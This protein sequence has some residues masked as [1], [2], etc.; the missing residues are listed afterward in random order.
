[1]VIQ[2]YIIFLIPL[3]LSLI[4]TPAVIRLARRIGA[5]DQPNER[6]IHKLPIPR[7]GGLAIYAS[8][9]LS[10]VLYYYFDPAIHP[11]SSMHPRTGV[12]LAVSL[13][14]VLILGIWDDVKQLSPG[15]KFFFQCLAAAIVYFAGFRIASITH[16]FSSSL[17]DLGILNFP[18]T[19]LWIVGITNAFNLIDGLDGLAGGIAFIASLTVCTISFIDGDL[20]TA[21]MALMLAGS[22][23][24][25]LR[26]NF[27]GARIFLGDSGSLFLGFSLAI[28]SMVSSTKGSTAFSILVPVLALGLPIMDTLLSMARRFLHSVFPEDEEPKTFFKKL[29]TMFLPDR[30]HIHHQLI[31]RG[32]SHR[33]VVLL[34][35]VVS[36]LFGLG[37]FMVTLA[38]N[39]SVTPVLIAIGVASVIG[40]SQLKYK[41]MAMLRDGALLPLYEWPLM[42]SI[43]FHGFLDLAFTILAYAGACYLCRPGLSFDDQFLK[44]IM[45]VSGIQISVFY[46]TGLYKGMLR[47]FGMGDVL[48]AFKSVSLASIITWTALAFLPSPWSALP[49]TVLLLDFYFL[50]SLVM[51]ARVSFHALNYLSRRDQCEGK[52]I[53]LYGANAQGVFIAQ[54]LLSRE[55]IRYCPVG[56]V[57]DNPALEGKQINGFPIFGGHLKIEQV[58]RRHHVSELLL[59]DDSIRPEI[60]KRIIRIV[61]L[62]DIKAKVVSIRLDDLAADKSV[63]IPQGFTVAEI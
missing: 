49:T 39:L 8:F 57:D 40:V 21:M 9:F 35:Y 12:M 2:L 56:F 41:E 29:L 51:G 17:L 42:Q 11:L 36:C 27:N 30:G 43:V 53:L 52:K 59:C 31:A 61:R 15:R 38:N 46:A 58:I 5:M 45:L 23:L 6:K 37:A 18:A 63:K 14:L 54:E 32:L 20:A 28:L 25:F 4:L 26:Y 7:L 22:V 48:K 50:L 34:L 3:I 1:M 13:T 19:L 33:N 47:Q 10:L 16:P 55:D 44:N 60:M 62:H 24:G